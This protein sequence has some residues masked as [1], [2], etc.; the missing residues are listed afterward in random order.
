[1]SRAKGIREVGY[2]DCPGGGQVIVERNVAYL[3]HVSLE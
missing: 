1:M 3:G 2:F